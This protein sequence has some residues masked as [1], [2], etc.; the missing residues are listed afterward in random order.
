[1]A[2]H[3]TITASN[4]NATGKPSTD[5]L[6][7]LLFKLGTRCFA[8]PMAQVRYIAPIPATFASH[9]EG[10][11]QHFVFENQPL[12]Y[13]P[14]WDRLG[15]VSE[16][17]EYENLQT[18]LPQ[19]RQDHQDWMAALEHAIR[20]G[21]AFSKARNPKECAFGKWYYSHTFNDRR[22]TLLLGQFETPH[23][24]IHALADQLLSLADQGRRDEALAIFEQEKSTTL[25]LLLSLFDSA[26]VLV[27]E[28]QRRIAIIVS[29]GDNTCALGADSVRDITTVPADQI[30]YPHHHQHTATAGL[31][32]LDNQEV[33]PLLDW[34]VFGE[35]G[36]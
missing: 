23:N 11:A 24:R 31:I 18:L 3:P 20:T 14:L 25:A 21:E 34:Q 32:I 1:M 36:D 19:R 22:L 7:L 33:V 27:K 4:A 35:T 8:L 5:P 29:D 10:V 6:E 16:F 2:H 26:G 28:L 30:T 12:S 15:I 17:I 9:G 13:L